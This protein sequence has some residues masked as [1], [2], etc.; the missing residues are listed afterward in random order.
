MASPNPPVS[1]LSVNASEQT[2]LLAGGSGR[3]PR[4]A[5]TKRHSAVELGTKLAKRFRCRR[6]SDLIEQVI[7]QL[8]WM[9]CSVMSVSLSRG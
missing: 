2:V 7:R 4:F 6:R 3:G 9:A 8:V 1:G 5:G